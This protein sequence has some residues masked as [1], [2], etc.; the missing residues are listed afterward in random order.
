MA[1]QANRVVV[2]GIGV[3]SPL[4]VKKNKVFFDILN[5]LSGIQKLEGPG[6]KAEIG[7]SITK[8][9]VSYTC[10]LHGPR[11]LD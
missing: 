8:L 4:G 11:T 3:I 10:K 7:N 6:K 2:T 9:L 1:L 5:R